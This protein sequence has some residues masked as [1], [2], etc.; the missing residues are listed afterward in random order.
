MK[1]LLSWNASAW[2]GL[3]LWGGLAGLAG[4][5][6]VGVDDTATGAEAGADLERLGEAEQKSTPAT[7]RLPGEW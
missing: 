3:V 7:Y 1:P 5:G 4:I 2:M 6:C